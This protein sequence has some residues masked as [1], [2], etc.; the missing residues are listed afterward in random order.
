MSKSLG[1]SFLTYRGGR[2]LWISVVGAVG[3]TLHYLHYRSQVVAY[4]G[5]LIGLTYGVIATIM[6]GVLMMLGIRK[7]SYASGV[8]T[9]QGWVSAHVYLGLLTL[10]LVPMHAGFR[11]GVDVHTLAFVLLAVVVVS[12]IVGILLYQYLPSRLTKYESGLQA[13]KIDK[14][15]AQLLSEM[16]NLVKNKSDALVRLY[17]AEV[18]KVNDLKVNGW[19]LLLRGSGGDLIARRSKELAEKVSSIPPEDQEAFHL[20]SQLLL[21]KTQL[22]ANLFNQMRLRNAMQAWLYVHVPV[23]VAMVITVGI[24]VLI[25]FYY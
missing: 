24:H 12:G 17:Q 3:L 16:R 22:E 11:F 14:E 4:G 25:V 9:L 8:G 18:A 15:I 1:N 6:I 23:S 19:S 20:M 10:L 21:Q 13:D 5:T 2:W 7:R